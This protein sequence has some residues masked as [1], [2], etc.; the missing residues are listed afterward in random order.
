M[1][2]DHHMI[3]LSHQSLKDMAKYASNPVRACCYVI[4]L[5]SPSCTDLA[6][7]TSRSYTSEEELSEFEKAHLDILI[8]A[9]EVEEVDEFEA[10]IREKAILLPKSRTKAIDWWCLPAQYTAFH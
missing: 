1:I 9:I 5:H 6:C 3:P 2:L 4:G 10:Y 8:E 7:C